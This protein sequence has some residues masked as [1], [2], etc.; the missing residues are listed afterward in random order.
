M[1]IDTDWALSAKGNLWRRI[2]NKI[3]VVGQKKDK[4]WW[5]MYDGNFAKGT[6]KS[7]NNAKRAAHELMINSNP[8]FEGEIDEYE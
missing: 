4:T 1:K 7:E 6:C 3:L 8:D 2:D 5:A